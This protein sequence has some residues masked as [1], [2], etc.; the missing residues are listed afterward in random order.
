MKKLDRRS[1]LK[2]GGAGLAG[3]AISRFDIPY[4]SYLSPKNALAMGSSNAWTFGVMADTQWKLTAGGEATCATGIIDALNNQFVGHQCKF[5]IQVGD[6]VDKESDKD[7]NNISYRTL[8]TRADHAQVLYDN[9]IGFFPVRGNHEASKTA[10]GEMKDL[11][12]QT[13]GQGNNAVGATNFDSPVLGTNGDALTG[14][15]YSFDYNNVRCVLIDQFTRFDGS[16]YPS[17]TSNN[18]NA[19]DQVPWVTSRLSSQTGSDRHAFV[20]SH[21]NLI[22]QNHKDVLFGGKLTDNATARDTFIKACANNGVRYCLGGHDHM[23]HRSLVSTSDKTASVGQIICSSNSYKFYIPAAGDDGRETPVTQELFTVGYYI[24]TVDGPRVTVDFYSAS[25][26]S[27]YGDIDMLDA[28]PFAFYLRERF[29]YSL[30]GEQYLVEH[31]ESYVGIESTYSGTKAK[32]LGG[33]NGNTETDKLGRQ[34]Q[35]TVC[36][37]WADATTSGAASPIFSLWGMMDN[38]SL[39]DANFTGLL[40]DANESTETDEFALA[41][42]YDPKKVRPSDLVSGRFVI[43]SKDDEENWVSSV[44]LNTGGAATFIYGPWKATYGL[45]TYGVDPRTKTAWAVLN[46]EGD[47]A[48][49]LMNV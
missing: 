8:P 1:F 15:S 20:F 18:N 5:V 26:G 35:K 44:D 42:T 28:P 25:H 37:G 33:T 14:L 40:P 22:G 43:I 23:H 27:D 36:T 30:N 48:L 24:F 29:G 11:F 21:K 31:G 49:K 16:N 47:F 2:I 45:G 46:H 7:A 41:I 9:G 39:Y 32:I 19:V 13:Q 38:L 12:P 6:L 4:L 10:A 34:L 17:G 3:L